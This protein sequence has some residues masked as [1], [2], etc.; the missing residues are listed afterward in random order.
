MIMAERSTI[1]SMYRFNK[2]NPSRNFAKKTLVRI[3]SERI[4]LLNIVVSAILRRFNLIVFRAAFDSVTIVVPI[5]HAIGS[6][7]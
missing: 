2:S 1:Q 3:L 5:F 7:W 4:G 6:V